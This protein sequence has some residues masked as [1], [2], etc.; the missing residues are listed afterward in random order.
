MQANRRSGIYRMLALDQPITL[1][2]SIGQT[3]K[4]TERYLFQ[5]R[6][7]LQA[8]QTCLLGQAGKDTRLWSDS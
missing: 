8:I 5:L 4:P 1:D 3:R 2:K 6:A 7:N